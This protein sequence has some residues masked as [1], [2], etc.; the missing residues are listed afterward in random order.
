MKKTLLIFLFT[1]MM[2]PTIG[3]AKKKVS[4]KVLKDKLTKQVEE[5]SKLKAQ[6][7]SVEHKLGSMNENYMSKTKEIKA[8]DLKV[9]QMKDEL[10]QSA[11]EIS[12]NYEATR[13]ILNHYLLDVDD[14]RSNDK[15]LKRKIYIKLLQNKISD[16]QVAQSNSKGLLG[17]VKEYEDRLEQSKRDE[18]ALYNLLT[19][20]ESK[21]KL[22]SQ[23]Y[24]SSLENK[25]EIDETLEEA[26]ARRKVKRKTKKVARSKISIQ[27]RRPLDNYLSLKGSKKGVTFKFNKV[28]PVYASNSGKVVYAGELASYGKVIMVDHGNEIRSVILGDIA[29]K[30]SKGDI[31]KDGEILA[32]TNSDPGLTKSLYYEVRKK[33]VAQNTLNILKKNNKRI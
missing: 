17:T 7:H 24:V 30:V 6:I 20:L 31:V 11:F 2:L 32:Y 4:V 10:N 22:L 5:V 27:L 9:Q 12:K 15:Y 19:D 1:F 23:K 33:N 14:E 18:E 16:L 13:K 25:N 29:I 21:K 26:I 3:L 28:S 8:L